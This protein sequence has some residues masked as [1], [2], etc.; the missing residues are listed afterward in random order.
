MSDARAADIIL[1]AV[2]F[3]C[4]FYLASQDAEGITFSEIEDDVGDKP[5][6]NGMT[7][8]THTKDDVVVVPYKHI[9]DEFWIA[10]RERDGSWV[11]QLVDGSG[12]SY[13]V[14]GAVSTSNGS[15]CVFVT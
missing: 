13:F 8:G 1:I 14:A 6:Y 5:H 4:A 2:T 11:N 7:K 12:T 9:N 15:V 10:Y 3:C